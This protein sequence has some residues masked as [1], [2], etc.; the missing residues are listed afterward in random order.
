MLFICLAIIFSWVEQ[1]LTLNVSIPDQTW[2]AL[3]ASLV[4]KSSVHSST[5]E[6]AK[7]I[8]LSLRERRK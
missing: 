2:S 8:L 3:D 7:R 5:G 1:L 6:R 4:Q